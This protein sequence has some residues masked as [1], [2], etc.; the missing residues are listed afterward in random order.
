MHVGWCSCLALCAL[1]I[2]PSRIYLQVKCSVLYIYVQKNCNFLRP[3]QPLDAL[4]NYSFF[5][6]SCGKFSLILL[7]H[8]HTEFIKIFRHINIAGKEAIDTTER[9]SN[10]MICLFY[11]APS[12]LKSFI[13]SVTLS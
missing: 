3:L 13:K 9:T 2:S 5:N 8:I 6:L 1:I 10:L 7:I 4:Q 11:F 12:G